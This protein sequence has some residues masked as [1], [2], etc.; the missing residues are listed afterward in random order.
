MYVSGACTCGMLGSEG[1]LTKNAFLVNT[2]SSAQ[3]RGVEVLKN[4]AG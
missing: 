3:L 4:G 2:S 1:R